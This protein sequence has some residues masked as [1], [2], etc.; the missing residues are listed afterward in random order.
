MK[1]ICLVFYTHQPLILK[2]YRFYEIGSNSTYFSET[3]NY[4][5]IRRLVRK[6][7]KPLNQALTE[8]FQ[9]NGNKFKISFSF[10]GITLDLL[11]FA[12]PDTIGDLKRLNELG[13][14]EFL[15]ESYSHSILSK[16]YQ[17][18]F[19]QQIL[20]QKN[21]ILNLFGQIP[22]TFVNNYGY[23]MQFLANS[24]PQLGINT[25]LQFE[26]IQSTQDNHAASSLSLTGQDALQVL[27]SDK[28]VL[29][30]FIEVKPNNGRLK[31]G[32]NTDAF[33]DWMLEIPDD[34][35]VVYV[36]LDYTELNSENT[37]DVGVL[38][39]IK[40]LPEKAAALNIGFCTP[41]ELVSNMPSKVIEKA[42]LAMETKKELDA[43]ALNGFQKEIIGILNNLKEKVY[44][45]NN[46]KILKT[47][48]Y[49][50]DQ[51]LF[52][53][54]Q[55]EE[56]MDSEK[57]QAVQSYINFRNILED[58]SQNIDQY[59]ADQRTASIELLYDKKAKSTSKK[60]QGA[61]WVFNTLF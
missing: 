32:I 6:K 58:F 33:L 16:K 7:Y 29:Q 46:T 40:E 21:K 15:S 44:Q 30:P 23:P 59:L 22:K 39:F 26:G 4:E 57:N 47:W 43:P 38:E 8:I 27:S 55:A 45:T 51:W 2:N 31:K 56:T 49:L 17:H 24:L 1:S 36:P 60:A 54:L 53:T 12:A 28:W 37:E 52:N 5:N 50:Q 18:E 34:N 48:F 19:M 42:L 13:A 9:S 3:H 35:E 20:N 14:V 41:S 61:T 10:S 25:L 11:E